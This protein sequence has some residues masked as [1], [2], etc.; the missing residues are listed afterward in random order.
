MTFADQ[1][2]SND[3]VVIAR[4]LEIAEPIDDPEAE[5]PKSLFE[6]SDVIKGQDTVREGMQFRSLL[7]GKYPLGNRFLVMGVDP[8]NVAWSTPMKASDRVVTYLKSI[9]GLPP[10]GPKRLAFF[11]QYFEDEEPVLAFDAYDE[12][13]LAPY[14]DILA[15]KDLMNRQ[16]LLKWIN[17][18]DTSTNRRRLYF[19]MLGVCG[20]PEDIELLETFIRSGDRK[21]QAGLDALIA[22]YL[23]LKK[24]AGLPLIVDTFLRDKEMEYVDTLAA[25]S[26]LRFHA[27]EVDHLPRTHI[28]D[29]LRTLLDRPNIADMIIPDLARWE[30]W[31]VMERLVKMFKEA[32]EESS[33]VRVS[34]ATYLQSCPKPEA[35]EYL[36]ELAKIDPD[37]IKRAEFYMDFTND[38]DAAAKDN[39]PTTESD[40]GEKKSA[41][42]NATT[43]ESKSDDGESKSTGTSKSNDRESGQDAASGN[44]TNPDEPGGDDSSAANSNVAAET[45]V[46]HRVPLVAANTV[47]PEAEQVLHGEPGDRDMPA[48]ASSNSATQDTTSGR[49]QNSLQLADS[50][51]PALRIERSPIAA[52]DVRPFRKSHVVLI[53]FASSV[54]LFVLLWSVINGWFERL[55]F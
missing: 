55:I 40:S 37:A 48:I 16:Q 22:A 17:D 24:E 27:T 49:S 5:L 51:P 12:F 29:A 44:E 8:P 11:Q 42:T 3:V 21:K 30:D 45:Y 54:L 18:P 35:K 20:Q 52:A 43:G 41:E 33:W 2:K 32:D 28:A 38:F 9:Q 50:A 47:G 53:P 19:T 46:A 26:A 34:V 6:I 31:S 4:L 13:A 1:I 36:Q 15:M 25:V 23:T 39:E 14:S 7:V 10:S